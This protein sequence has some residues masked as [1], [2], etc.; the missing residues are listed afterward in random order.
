MKP[1]QSDLNALGENTESAFHALLQVFTN[2]TEGVLFDALLPVVTLDTTDLTILTPAQSVSI[3]GSVESLL[4]YSEIFDLDD[5]MSGLL[6]LRVEVYFVF[7]RV[8]VTATRNFLSVDPTRNVTILQNAEA[9]IATIIQPSVVYLWTNDLGD[10]SQVPLLG[11]M[12][13]GYIKL[14]TVTYAG[15]ITVTSEPLNS[16]T[17]PDSLIVPV[18]LHGSSHLPGG[19]DPIPLAELSN[20]TVYG[21]TAGLMPLGAYSLA[22]NSVSDLIPGQ[23]S[24]FFVFSTVGSNEVVENTFNPKLIRVSLRTDPS[25]TISGVSGGQALG[26]KFGVA[27]PNTGIS[28]EAARRDHIH[29]LSESGLVVVN[30]SQDIDE[31]DSGTIITREITAGDLP[32]NVRLAQIL[33]VKYYWEPPNLDPV[34][35]HDDNLVAVPWMVTQIAGSGLSTLGV[36]TNILS[37]T[38]FQMEIGAYGLAYLT[39]AMQTEIQSWTSPQYSHGTYPKLGTLHIVVLALREGANG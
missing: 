11:P 7:N 4:D 38:T 25:L 34:E 28:S 16:F 14:A 35:S 29:A 39:Q 3:R 33:D 30:L 24:P 22:M 9:E 5:G 13:V 8:P 36:R 31:F 10:P 1:L 20:T 21:S 17:L 2:N 27:G 26:V 12:G 37:K 6:D 19:L 18:Q 23:D 15:G 32:N